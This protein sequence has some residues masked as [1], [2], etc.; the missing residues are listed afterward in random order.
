MIRS[1]GNLRFTRLLSDIIS[2]AG[3][4]FKPIRQTSA[5]FGKPKNDKI[6]YRQN[7]EEMVGFQVRST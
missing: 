5:W 1:K 2:G 4:Y 3:R 7:N 6:I